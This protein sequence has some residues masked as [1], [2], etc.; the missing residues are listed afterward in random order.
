V[1]G[2]E[3]IVWGRLVATV[4]LGCVAAGCLGGGRGRPTR[5]F[6]LD[7]P[8]PPDPPL[9]ASSLVVG[10]GPVT[11]PDYLERPQLV[12]R[13]AE[14]EVDLHDGERWGE[15]LREAFFRSLA[16]GLSRNAGTRRI[17]PYPWSRTVPI[18]AAVRVYVQRFERMPD[19]EV[20][21][22]A[23]YFIDVPGRDEPSAGREVRLREPTTGDEAEA[24]VAAMS[25]V[26]GALSREIAADVRRA[27]PRPRGAARS[28]GT[29]SR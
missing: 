27:L 1:R 15:P 13:A 2:K 22:A 16:V 24:T 8:P 26:A 18:D 5:Y 4:L 28:P 20:E 19:G 29:A 7:T 3:A 25:R 23:R 14:F 12:T 6:T 17:V 9:P 21:L 11:L 10:L